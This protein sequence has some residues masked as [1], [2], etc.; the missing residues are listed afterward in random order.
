MIRRPPRSTQSRSSAASDVYK[1]QG[2]R[3]VAHADVAVDSGRRQHGLDARVAVVRGRLGRRGGRGLAA[4]GGAG[5]LLLGLVVR[6]AL[7]RV[8]AEDLER[9]VADELA[10]AVVVGG[11]HDLGGASVSYTH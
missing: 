4:A 6:V 3:R 9:L 10:L 7:E 8:A 1:R 5:L 2:E 11:D